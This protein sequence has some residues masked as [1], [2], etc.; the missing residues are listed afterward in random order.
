[1]M[2]ERH[3]MTKLNNKYKD[4]VWNTHTVSLSSMWL[5]PIYVA[6]YLALILQGIPTTTFRSYDHSRLVLVGGGGRPAVHDWGDIGQQF[7][8]WGMGH[9]FMVL[10]K[11]YVWVNSSW[12]GK[13]QVGPHPP[14]NRRTDTTGSITFRCTTYVV[15][16]KKY[17]R[18][19]TYCVSCFYWIILI[20]VR[21]RPLAGTLPYLYQLVSLTTT[22]RTKPQIKCFKLNKPRHIAS[23]NYNPTV[24][25]LKQKHF[26]FL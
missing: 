13:I 17:W 16:E 1:M 11:G 6:K 23:R 25:T 12:F 8:A 10:G 5:T 26:H 3:T 20:K 14:V 4:I 21:I 18:F 7:M 19:K 9:Q 15:D 22:N 2:R 24:Q